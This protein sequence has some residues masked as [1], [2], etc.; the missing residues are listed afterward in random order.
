MILRFKNTMKKHVLIILAFS[1]LIITSCERTFIL[2]SGEKPTIELKEDKAYINGV[3]GKRFYKK[4]EKFIAENPSVKT[5]VLEIVPGSANDEWNVKSCLLLYKS[6]MNTELKSYSEIASGGVDL[7]MSGNTRTI[8]EGA[9]IGVHSWSDGKKEGIEYP[10]DSEQHK[11]F[12]DLFDKIDV[13]TAFYWY[14][15]KAASAND[16]YWMTNEEIE[17]YNLKRN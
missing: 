1:L 13:D 17:L 11:I 16:I 9:R 14:T 5:C 4:F 15:L 12:L 6:G 8:E 10:R 7:F 3:L 2:L